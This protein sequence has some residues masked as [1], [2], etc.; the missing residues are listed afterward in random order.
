M[1][2]AISDSFDAVTDTDHWFTA[3][4]VF[5]GF[6]APV[7]FKAF[8]EDRLSI[9][10]PDEVYGVVV[11]VAAEFGPSDYRRNLQIGGGLYT[12]DQLAERF[13]LKERVPGGN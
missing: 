9:D 7:V 11:V 8:L 3:V 5:V 13:G 1:A 6:I 12:V 4:V 10:L 2:N